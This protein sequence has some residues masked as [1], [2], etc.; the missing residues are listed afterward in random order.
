MPIPNLDD[1]ITI[2]KTF[3]VETSP[4]TLLQQAASTVMAND[5][6]PVDIMK[7]I[8]ILNVSEDEDDEDDAQEYIDQAIQDLESIKAERQGSS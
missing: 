4:V 3:N 1:A 7:A 8:Q 5:I 2:L 6:R